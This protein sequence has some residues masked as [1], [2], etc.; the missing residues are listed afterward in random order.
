MK[1][2]K[3]F[4]KKEKK[5]KSSTKWFIFVISI[6]RLLLIICVWLL[7]TDYF[8]QKVFIQGNI[9]LGTSI[10]VNLNSQGAYA[11]SITYDGSNIPG[12]NVQ[13]V[14]KMSLPLNSESTVVRV[15]LFTC[16]E[17]G[18]LSIL[19]ATVADEIWLKEGDYYYYNDIL[20][21]GVIT[22]FSQSIT[23]PTNENFF[24]Y[25]KYYE[26]IVVFE[27]LLYNSGTYEVGE[28]WQNL[29]DNWLSNI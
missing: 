19:N 21:A 23:L 14:I 28:V 17:G 24:N 26:I 15:K 2:I 13:Q 6:L 18:N 27:T 20:T 22:N 16:D 9:P 1:E 8:K 10:T 5:L 3:A 29:P 11:T 7:M 25:D 12:A 4:P